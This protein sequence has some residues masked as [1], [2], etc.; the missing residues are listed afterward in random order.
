MMPEV[1]EVAGSLA[2]ASQALDAQVLRWC[3]HAERDCSNLERRVA[4]R[5]I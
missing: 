3:V 4:M 5:M 1:L 2:E